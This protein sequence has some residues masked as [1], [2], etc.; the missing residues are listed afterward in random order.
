MGFGRNFFEK[1]QIW[2]SE[3]HFGEVT[4]DARPWFMAHSWKGHGRLSIRVNWTAFAIYYAVQLGCFRRN[5]T[6]LH[7]NFTWTGSLPPTILGIRRLETLGYPTVKTAS[8]CVPAFWYNTGVWRTNG[9]T[10]GRICRSMYNA[11]KAS[12]A[13]RCKNGQWSTIYHVAVQRIPDRRYCAA[14]GAVGKMSP[15]CRFVQ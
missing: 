12:F 7:S 13:E 11:C 6:A 8:L 15:G 1:W 2:V 4:G 9:Q 10:D 14:E 3:P 5:S